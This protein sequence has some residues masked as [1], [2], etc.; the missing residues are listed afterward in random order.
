MAYLEGPWA[1][2]GACQP[3]PDSGG[4]DHNVCIL[5]GSGMYVG[6]HG[7]CP[8]R[9]HG[10]EWRLVCART[11]AGRNVCKAKCVHGRTEKARRGTGGASKGA[12]CATFVFANV[13]KKRAQVVE[14]ETD[15]EVSTVAV[16]TRAR[17]RCAPKCRLRL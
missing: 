13:K 15:T 1:Q 9:M 6:A 17:G 16:G 7:S 8:L 11:M 4:F 2:R 10:R 3:T 12:C 5:K 14:W